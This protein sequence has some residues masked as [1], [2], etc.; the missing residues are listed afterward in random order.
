MNSIDHK[1]IKYQSL[2]QKINTNFQ[3]ILERELNNPVL[4]ATQVWTFVDDFLKV[5][6][7]KEVHRQW[8]EG[9]KPLVFKNDILLIQTKDKFSSQWINTHYQDLIDEL[10][11]LKSIKFSCFF[12]APKN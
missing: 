8:F 6:L 5:V 2:K 10:I 4:K 7:D 11:K 9:V 3:E 12:I 1:F